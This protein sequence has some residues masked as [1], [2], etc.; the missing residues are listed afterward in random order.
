MKFQFDRNQ[1]QQL[2][3]IQSVVN[4]FEGQPLQQGDFEI[5][6]TVSPAGVHAY[7]AQTTMEQGVGNALTLPRSLIHWRS[8]VPVAARPSRTMARRQSF[9][10][11]TPTP[12]PS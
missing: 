10:R 8:S 1:E 3:A 12:Q 11:I 7:G 9:A 5:S 6:F 2:Q 4:L